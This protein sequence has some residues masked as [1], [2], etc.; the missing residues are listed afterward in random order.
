M[1]SPS[2][3]TFHCLQRHASTRSGKPAGAL[4]LALAGTLALACSPDQPTPRPLPAPDGVSPRLSG[5]PRSP[6]IASYRIDARL[7]T[8]ARTITARQRLHWINRAEHP[9]EMLPFHLYMNAFKNEQSVF[10]R[11]SRGGHRTAR[12]SEDGWGWIDVQEVS[13][14]GTTLRVRYPDPDD[15][16]TVME[17]Y[18]AAPLEPGEAVDVDMR[19]EVQ[20]PE[21]FARTGYA[22]D[23][24]MIGQWFPKI[25]VLVGAPGG[26]TWHCPPFHAN[27]EFFADFGTYHVSLTVPDTHVVAATGVLIRAVANQDDTRTLTYRAEDVHDFAWMADPHMEMIQATATTALGDVDVRVY[28]RPR[29]EAFARR[30]L[31]AGVG[32]IE[33]FSRMLVPYPWPIM[34]IIDPPPEA[35]S[36]AGGMEYPTLV[37]TAGDSLFAFPGI[38]VPESVTVHE[39]GHNWFQGI[40]ASNE[41]EEAWL[42]EGVNQYVESLVMEELYGAGTGFIDWYGLRSAPLPLFQAGTPPLSS[43]P[44]P[45]A[46]APHAFPDGGSYAGATYGKTAMALGTL[47]SI[48]GADAL[49]EALRTYARRF[50]F[51]HPTG[52]DLFATLTGSLDQDLSWFL[53]PAFHEVGAV[54]YDVR[55]VQCRE[56]HEAR[57]VFGRGAERRTVSAREAPDTG[58]WAC[59]VLIVNVGRVP[60]PVDVHIAFADG[61]TTRQ[62]WKAAGDQ[63]WQRY[64][65]EHTAPVTEVVIDPEGRVLLND[66]LGKRAWR[67]DAAAGP[68]RRAGARL[69]HWTQTLM[70]IVGLS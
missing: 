48:V 14:D 34:S 53:H 61:T 36:G 63:R 1:S 35:A 56:Q 58:A 38:R 33:A 55:S 15:D 70:Q 30:H 49:R 42:D 2:R 69:Q 59:E 3:R 17:A 44:M 64:H 9:V 7:D 32:A 11:E 66:S 13:V 20:L 54:A 68:T 23:F 6:R 27:S 67:R 4:A 26:E 50:Q 65:L 5:A 41:T 19:F 40:L 24:F 25:G 10:M 51:A 45:I 43:L 16:E 8:E 57:G 22:G 12:R 62:R 47:E 31:H 46:T 39:V 29:Q 18:L 28:H 21:V 60:A 37:T 52:T